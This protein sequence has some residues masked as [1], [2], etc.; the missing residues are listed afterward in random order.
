M[1]SEQILPIIFALMK[2]KSIETLDISGNN[3]GDTVCMILCKALQVIY[4]TIVLHHNGSC[5]NANIWDCS[6]DG[7]ALAL[8]ARG[9]GIDTL[10][11]HYFLFLWVK[12]W[13]LWQVNT[14]LN[15]LLWDDNQITAHGYA[16]FKHVLAHKNTTL[17]FVPTPTNDVFLAYENKRADT[18]HDINQVRTLYE[19][20]I[21]KCCWSV[22]L[23]ARNCKN[24]EF[25]AP[26]SAPTSPAAPSSPSQPKPA[27]SDSSEDEHEPARPAKKPGNIPS[28]LNNY[29][30]L[31]PSAKKKPMGFN[32]LINTIRGAK[33]Y[34]AEDAS[35]DAWW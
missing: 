17:M 27:D 29:R 2:N 22:Q 4:M 16:M 18:I 1:T 15:T 11:F 34:N 20:I 23:L 14:S 7:R 10:L 31:F 33:L 3:G 35:G 19:T 8:H 28:M 5:Q 25:V 21:W 6:S 12:F 32:Y 13:H 24:A 30:N 26:V 9:T